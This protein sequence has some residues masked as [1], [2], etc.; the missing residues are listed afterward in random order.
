MLPMGK[1]R[2]EEMNKEGFNL[3]DVYD[4]EIAPL[5]SRIIEICKEHKL[6]MFA[7]FLYLNDPD[8]SGDDALCT[9]NLMFEERPIP[10]KLLGLIKIVSPSRGS[11]LRM[12]VTKN[13]GSV[14]D[15]VIFP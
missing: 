13:D 2:E 1:N 10:E 9:T 6:P 14:E 7:T 5:M 15:T 3:E 12:R 4:E 11:P 8:E